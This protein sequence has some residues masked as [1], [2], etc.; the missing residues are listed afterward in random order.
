LW[1]RVRVRGV[2][3]DD[4]S[5]VPHVLLFHILVKPKRPFAITYPFSQY[6]DLIQV[7]LSQTFLITVMKIT[8]AV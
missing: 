5:V 4:N 8:N 6:G 3:P 1:E 2:S 7:S